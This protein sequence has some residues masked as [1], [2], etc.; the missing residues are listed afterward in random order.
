MTNEKLEQI[1][2]PAL[3]AYELGK[4]AAMQSQTPNGEALGPPV[5]PFACV[6]YRQVD[7]KWKVVSI[8]QSE[9]DLEVALDA[10]IAKIERVSK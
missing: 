7:G 1:D 10:G 4:A 5:H 9:H 8:T 6:N 3:V 2:S